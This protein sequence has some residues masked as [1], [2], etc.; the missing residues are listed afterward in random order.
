MTADG[1]I[2]IN[3][4]IL[5]DG[6]KTGTRNIKNE[7]NGLTTT[8]KK[9]GAVV[10]S[11]F[12]VKKI[13]DFG[14][15][16]IELSSDLQEVQNVVDSVFTTMSNRVDEFAKNA[17]VTAGLSETMAKKYTGT[18]GAMAK[19]FGFAES[20]AFDMSTALTQLTGDVA[21]FYNLTQDEAYTKL[22][23][24][25]TGETESLKELGVVMT[26]SA[27]DA[28]AMA[29]GFGKTTAAMSE[30]EKV[31]L[32]YQF[33][34]NQL[35]TASG[36]FLRTSDG[37]ANQVRVLK[38]QIESLKATIGSGLINLFTPV[39]KVINLLLSKLATV[40]NAFKSFT[41]LITG[42]KSSGQ[43]TSADAGLD[44]FG[45]VEAAEG[46]QG[47]ADATDNI[48][49][50]TKEA[51]KAQDK[52]LSGLDEVRRFGEE[53]ADAGNASVPGV[54]GGGAGVG[55][56]DYGKAAEG[57]TV[58]EKLNDKAVSLKNVLSTM[59]IPFEKAWENNGANVVSSVKYSLNSIGSLL[60]SI[61]KS[62]ATVWT[63]GTGEK[64][65]IL[66]L[67]IVSNITRTVGNLA[68]QFKKAWDTNAVGTAI[69]QGL[70]NIVNTIMGF[71]E[72]IAADTARWA[73]NI[74][75][76]PLLESVKNLLEAMQ[77]IIEIIGDVLAE[78]YEDVIL[79]AGTYL[80][81][82]ALPKI[83]DK[84][85][86]LLGYIK[87]H[88]DGVK[89]FGKVLVGAFAVS[90]IIPKVL[91]LKNAIDGLIGKFLG[92][93][94]ASETLTKKTT[95]L[96]TTLSGLSSI[97]TKVSG[98]MST[99]GT[100][101][102]A[103]ASALGIGIVGTVAL[104]R[105]LASLVE[106]A[107]GGNGILSSMGGSLNDLAA[108]MANA[109][110]IT[111]EQQESIRALIDAN[112]DMG[113]SSSEMAANVV[114][115]FD[116]LGVSAE[117]LNVV[118]SSTGT[119]FTITAE[120]AEI[121]NGLVDSL[122]SGISETATMIDLSSVGIKDAFKGMKQ[123]LTQLWIEGTIADDVFYEL[124]G[125]LSNMKASGQTA[126]T[127]LDSVVTV[128]E[129]VGIPTEQFIKLLGEKVPGALTN[130][131]NTTTQTMEKT[132]EV[133]ESNMK[134]TED[135]VKTHTEQMQ[136]S[137]ESATSDIETDI[138]TTFGGTAENTESNWSASNT[139]VQEALNAMRSAS[140][141][142]MRSIFKSVESYTNSIWNITSNNWDAIALKISSAMNTVSDR[143]AN[144]FQN[145]RLNIVNEMNRLIYSLNHL[146]NSA[147]AV[148]NRIA[149]SLSFDISFPEPTDRI[150]GYSRISMNIPQ[151]GFSPPVPYLATGAVI[152]PNAPF[153][154]MLGDQRNGTNLEAPE[155]LIRQIMREELANIPQVGGQYTFIGQINRRTLFEEFMEEAQIVMSQTGNNPF[156]IA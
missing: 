24:V 17:A 122:G 33:V 51:K 107:Q 12:A 73:D 113:A 121:L 64:T 142:S 8:L 76:Y 22:K 103:S 118:L 55:T 69:M 21:S 70:A 39:I 85:T 13:A 1:S 145:M 106:T 6:F 75:F 59:F 46:A 79:P 28:Y 96:K 148:R 35:S 147:T 130:V 101:T 97:T 141:S 57:E 100:S 41:E 104:T 10:G 56:V 140:S 18:F 152:P 43:T 135:S 61:G 62:F 38:L 31:A 126:Q 3:T 52:Y 129:E 123:S 80:I 144:V 27:L 91:L 115:E 151:V 92:T 63:N 132:A 44:S 109:N 156:D 68:K 98:I 149:K 108:A 42:N 116:N 154:A 50:A 77:P 133:V 124:D 72:R 94:A 4:R 23:S 54:S 119:Q 36:D 2:V 146:Q 60:S 110:I 48:T 117:Q 95:V 29:N 102:L 111:T 7:M 99:L 67:N 34:M 125:S 82:E 87:E 49:Q 88:E 93:S 37:W 155:G 26:Q 15:S 78:I 30:Q 120:N 138:S 74:D 114:S 127:A 84:L 19:S 131:Q 11:V 105:K 139:S 71:V 20:E 128:L 25:F 150:V 5:T 112:E 143:V 66:L 89:T 47:V 40:A 16:A 9:F 90:K 65:L 32:R 58:F 134:A 136:K 53:N 153:M 14:K 81:E 83:L 45:Y 86:G 137:A